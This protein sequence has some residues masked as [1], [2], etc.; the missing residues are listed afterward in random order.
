MKE[1]RSGALLALLI[2]AVA[3]GRPGEQDGQDPGSAADPP[4]GVPRFLPGSHEFTFHDTRGN[5]DRPITVRYHMPEGYAPETP[6]VFVMHGASRTGQQYFDDWEPHA[7]AH[8]FLLVVPEFDAD[9]Y[10]G[11]HWYNLGNVFPDP[12]AAAADPDATAT[13]AFEL[14]HR[15]RT[16]ADRR[17]G[18]LWGAFPFAVP[19]NVS[20]HPAIVLPVGFVDG[21]PVAIQLVG[22]HNAD[23]DLLSL[24]EQLESGLNLRPFARLLSRIP[25][26]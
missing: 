11:S 13:P 3:C 7:I 19:F 4:P 22:R 26:S 6:I 5:A 21:L 25:A 8:D 9:N 14:G 23:L 2:L 24:A 16:I 15:P 12:D 18:R 20:G 1:R 17:V 10:P